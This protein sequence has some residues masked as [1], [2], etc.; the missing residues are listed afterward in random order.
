MHRDD[1]NHRMGLQ[2]LLF[3]NGVGH[4]AHRGP[5]IPQGIVGPPT[6]VDLARAISVTRNLGHAYTRHNLAIGCHT[7]RNLQGRLRC[8]LLLS[9]LL[10]GPA[11]FSH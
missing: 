3:D 9:L 2:P 6:N 7:Q 11:T 10:V 4:S 5:R 1:V 8:L